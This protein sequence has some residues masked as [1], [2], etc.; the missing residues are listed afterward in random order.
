MNLEQKNQT[1]TNAQ[2]GINLTKENDFGNANATNDL[3]NRKRNQT[4]DKKEDFTF[5]KKKKSHKFLYFILFAL[6]IG[7]IYYCRKKNNSNDGINYSQ[8]SKYSYYDF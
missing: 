8:I 7:C 6:I 3:L 1:I 4:N 5:K 2:N